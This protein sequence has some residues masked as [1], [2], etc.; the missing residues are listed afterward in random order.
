MNFIKY[1]QLYQ[2]LSS[3]K[4][5]YEV[6]GYYSN[7]INSQRTCL[8]SQ[9]TNQFQQQ[10]ILNYSIQKPVNKR[11]LFLLKRNCNDCL[12]EQWSQFFTIFL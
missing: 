11:I 4:L 8:A 12:H 9:Q 3:E 7:K 5:L 1:K 6:S 10:T 2:V